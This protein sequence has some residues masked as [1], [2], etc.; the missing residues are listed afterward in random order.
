MAVLHVQDL[1][2]GRSGQSV[3]TGL[4]FDLD[5]G[6]GLLLTGPNGA[7]KTT[8]LR[9]L[10]GL[11]PALEGQ[12]QGP[13]RVVFS[14]HLDGMKS[15][16]T[17]RENLEFLARLAEGGG[18]GKALADWNLEALANRRAADLSAGQRRRLGLARLSLAPVPL[19]LLDEP[20]SSLDT[21]SVALFEGALLR[22]LARGG[23]AVIATHLPLALE[24]LRTLKLE[25]QVRGKLDLEAL[26]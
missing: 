12:I 3:A 21:A 6:E 20:T 24:G 15:A 4:S 2:V 5:P 7:G 10:A 22:H 25:P 19:W 9:T 1:S 18:I 17:V 8:L 26:W 14:G 23:A 11:L 16:L 13:E